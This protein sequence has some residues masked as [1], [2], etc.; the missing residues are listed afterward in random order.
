MRTF[1]V[2]SPQFFVFQLEG[3]ETVY[4]IPTL[5]SMTNR[6]AREFDET[7]D[8]YNKQVE[9]LRKYIGDVVDD[10][11]V[12]ETINIITAWTRATEDEGASVGES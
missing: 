11:S 3:D 1:K 4:K 6:E 8:H 7:T 5:M 10:I 2:D 12:T 9:W